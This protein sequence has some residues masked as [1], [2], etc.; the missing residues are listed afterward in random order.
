M[1]SL[2]KQIAAVPATPT[3]R[4]RAARAPLLL[5]FAARWTAGAVLLEYIAKASIEEACFPLGRPCGFNTVT[6]NVARFCWLWRRA[7]LRGASFDG[8]PPEGGCG[9]RASG[10]RSSMYSSSA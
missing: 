4:S 1:V 6:R 9:P 2:R 10:S 5:A 7:L 3:T 8:L